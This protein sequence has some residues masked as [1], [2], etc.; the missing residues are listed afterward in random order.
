MKLQ[1]L[2]LHN[3]A[4]HRHKEI[5]FPASGVCVLQGHNGSGK[6]NLINALR[7][8][9]EGSVPGAL[10]KEHFLT[11][12]EEEGYV[13]LYFESNGTQGKLERA[14]HKSSSKLK[15]GT[16]S[17]VSNKEMLPLRNV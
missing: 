11:W 5:E 4:Q 8:V 1:K 14:L 16:F 9:I 17:T 2:I 13:E 12:G 6:S 10:S 15:F 7:F 3:F